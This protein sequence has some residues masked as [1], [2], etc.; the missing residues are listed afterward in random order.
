MANFAVNK[1]NQF[2]VVKSLSEGTDGHLASTDAVGSILPRFNEKYNELQFEYKSPGGVIVSDRIGIDTVTHKHAKKAEKDR[3]PLITKV[4]KLADLNGTAANNATTPDGTVDVIPGED[5]IMG[6][7][8]SHYIGI[9]DQDLYYVNAAVHGTDGMK[10]AEFYVRLA[11]SIARNLSREPA[12]LVD[13]YL[14]TG[15]SFDPAKDVKVEILTSE[16]TEAKLAAAIKANTAVKGVVVKERILD[17][18]EQ[19][20]GEKM[21]IDFTISF[22]LISYNSVDVQWG[23]C[24]DV[25]LGSTAA[26]SATVFDGTN[27]DKAVVLGNGRKTADMEYFFMGERGDQERHAGWPNNVPTKYLVDPDKEYDYLTMNFYW[28]PGDNDGGVRSTKVITL[29]AEKGTVISSIVTKLGALGIEFNSK[30]SD[31]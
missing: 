30:E 23:T 13:V 19:G 1:V 15:A 11:F 22:D 3:R 28:S 18:Y 24:E 26:A 21:P 20:I 6:L 8:F 29:V 16:V 27:A 31:F 2:Y 7:E 17:T 10:A 12:P 5:Y 25:T 14:L 9:S 4:I